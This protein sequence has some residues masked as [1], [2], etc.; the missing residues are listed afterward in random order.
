MRTVNGHRR[1][2]RLARRA[3]LA[4]AMAAAVPGPAA[5]QSGAGRFDVSIGGLWTGA[6]A[7][8][9]RNA[10]ETRNQAGGGVRAAAC[11]AAP[12][13]LFISSCYLGARQGACLLDPKPDNRGRQ[14][15]RLARRGDL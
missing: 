5:A 11:S 4:L 14:A 3:A 15:L 8:D 6:Y 7:L 13:F 12:L 1:P 2:R 9:P 10:T